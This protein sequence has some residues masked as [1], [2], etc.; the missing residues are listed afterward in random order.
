MKKHTAPTNGP[1]LVSSALQTS[2]VAGT[3]LDA[4][5][6]TPNATEPAML[7]TPIFHTRCLGRP[8]PTLRGS[9]TSANPLATKKAIEPNASGRH[10]RS[11]VHL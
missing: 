8:T 2:P 9:F 6:E 7:A 3:I 5:A 1:R 4:T 11:W 10:T